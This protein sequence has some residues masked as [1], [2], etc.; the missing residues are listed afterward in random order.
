MI[1]KENNKQTKLKKKT[2]KWTKKQNDMQ[3]KQI[4]KSKWLGNW[5]FEFYKL[6]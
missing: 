1:S 2:S 5:K 3:A 6:G 4:N